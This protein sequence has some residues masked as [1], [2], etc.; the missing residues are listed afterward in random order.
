VSLGRMKSALLACIASLVLAT[1]VTAH[2]GDLELGAS[3]GYRY[4]GGHMPVGPQGSGLFLGTSAA[5]TFFQR[6]PADVGFR[7]RL[8]GGPTA[9]AFIGYRFFEGAMSLGVTGSLTRTTVASVTWAPDLDPVRGTS[10]GIY[11]RTYPLRTR[12]FEGWVSLGAE[13]SRER[14]TFP[15]R[16]E[17]VHITHYGLGLPLTVALEARVTP[18][19]AV[20]PSLQLTYVVGRH[21]CYD[22]PLDNNIDPNT[23]LAP[24]SECTGDRNVDARD[25]LTFAASLG[26]RG[27]L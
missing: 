11:L 18:T 20:G 26:V 5:V 15:I 7:A 3:L 16:S 19:I 12:A 8:I 6:L 1:S 25:F 23:S 17:E 9:R 22:G 27:T 4:Q 24:P 21:A 2:A 14:L 10:Y 13:W